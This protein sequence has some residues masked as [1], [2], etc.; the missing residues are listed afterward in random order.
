MSKRKLQIE[1]Q[2]LDQFKQLDISKEQYT[3]PGN[4]AAEVLWQAYMLGDIEDKKVLDLG[5]GTGVLGIGA[6]ILGAK[7][8]VFIDI[9]DKALEV[10]QNNIEKLNL[11][12]SSY[13][14]DDINNIHVKGDTII[15]NPPFGTKQK[16][17]DKTFLEKA[18]Q[19]GKVIY[20]FHKTNTLDFVKAFC[21]D[22]KRE[23]T[24]KWDFKYPLKQSYDFHEKKIKDIEVSVVRIQN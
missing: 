19:I 13:I 10:T 6:L 23:I 5:C 4:I 9:D 12:N 1:L 18:I 21:R 17:A 14:H 8:T 20:S 11:E 16:H 2:K 24:H 22:N 7:E 3:T 15:M